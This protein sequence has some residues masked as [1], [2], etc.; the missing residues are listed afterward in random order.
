MYIMCVHVYT[1][2]YRYKHIYFKHISKDG[3]GRILR[4]PLVGMMPEEGLV[5][6][7]LHFN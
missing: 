6:Y 2:A 1:H 4:E 7:L 5:P 3:G